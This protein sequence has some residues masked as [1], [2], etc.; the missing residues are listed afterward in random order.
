MRAAGNV[1]LPGAKLQ[2]LYFIWLFNVLAIHKYREKIVFRLFQFN[3]NR[4]MVAGFFPASYVLV[5][6]TVD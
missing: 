3:P 5:N 6:F 2:P 4:C 1:V